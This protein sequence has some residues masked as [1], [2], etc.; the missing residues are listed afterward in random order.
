[1]PLRRRTAL[2]SYAVS[3]VLHAGLVAGLVLS[4]VPSVKLPAEPV[5]TAVRPAADEPESFARPVEP[6]GDAAS[7]DRSGVLPGEDVLAEADPEDAS[8]AEFTRQ[9]LQQAREQM[10]DHTPAEQTR[11]LEE[12]ARR[13]DN[14]SSAESL[15]QLTETIAPWIGGDSRRA[16]EPAEVAD[17]EPFD[18]STAQVSD[19]LKEQTGE[20]VQYVAVLVDAAGRSIRTPLDEADGEALY[21]VFQLMKKFPLLETVYRKTVM[22]LLDQLIEEQQNAAASPQSDDDAEPQQQQQQD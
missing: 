21:D 8:L 22:G 2:F 17:E 6:A 18:P 9:R 15:E 3:G 13:L 10:A 14:V 16:T 5:R 20:S 19:V 7:K 1:M 4:H 11:Q 12:L